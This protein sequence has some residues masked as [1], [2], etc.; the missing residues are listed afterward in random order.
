MITVVMSSPRP[1]HLGAHLT[2]PRNGT[3]NAQSAPCPPWSSPQSGTS[4]KAVFRTA[5]RSHLSELQENQLPAGHPLIKKTKQNARVLGITGEGGGG[6]THLLAAS[7]RQILCSPLFWWL[8]L[9]P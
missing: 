2:R 3:Q 6:G 5:V 1:K 7:V 9:L 8:T 4:W